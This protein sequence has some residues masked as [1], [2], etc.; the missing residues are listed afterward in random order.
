MTEINRV[1]LPSV[2]SLESTGGHR[3]GTWLAKRAIST[4]RDWLLQNA[5]FCGTDRSVRVSYDLL[6]L[7]KLS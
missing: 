4:E 6:V 7:S 1:A 5:A 3:L 2:T